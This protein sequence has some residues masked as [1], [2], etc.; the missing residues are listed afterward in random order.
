[1]HSATDTTITEPTCVKGDYVLA[2]KFSD[3][4][5][6]DAW[7]VGYYLGQLAKP[8]GRHLVGDSEGKS[9]RP[10]GYGY[11]ARIDPEFGSWLLD[12]AIYLERCPPGSVNLWDMHKGRARFFKEREARALTGAAHGSRRAEDA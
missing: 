11:V 9:F 12:G 10:N 8:D 1:M 7:A 4:D 3:G 2:T 5:P 6:G